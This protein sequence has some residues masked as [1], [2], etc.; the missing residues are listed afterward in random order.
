[1]ISSTS[2][3]LSPD[4]DRLWTDIMDLSAIVDSDSP[5]WTREVFSDPYKASRSWTL[6]RMRAAGL[7]AHIDGAGN[8]VGR[9][10]GTN[11]N[12]PAIITGSHTDTVHSGGRFDGVVG[13]LGAIEA[14]RILQESGTRLTSDLVVMDFL[15]EEANG[16]GVSCVGSR[17]VAGVLEA[18]HLARKDAHG[19]SMGE[20]IAGFGADPNAAVS[21]AWN[22]RNI[23]S[24]IELHVEQGPMLERS[25]SQIGVVTS[26]AGIERVMA[27]FTGR[28]DHAGTTPMDQRADALIAAAEAIL[29]VER[30]GCGAPVHGVSTTGRI[31]TGHGAFNVVPD[32]ATIW[33][34]IRSIDPSWLGGARRSIAEK[35][36]VDAA[37]RG[38][39]VAIDL[40]NDQDPV[41]AAQSMQD[42]V[43]AASDDLGYSWEAVPS[44]AG[45]DAAHMA[46]LGPMGMIFVPSQ[47]GRSHCPDEYTD[48]IQLSNGVHVL[49]NTIRRL[50]L[51]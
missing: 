27:V 40:L 34:E 41:P 6:A 17:A 32:S 18:S 21:M 3:I 47:D 29:T 9:L 45:H 28:A 4:A 11:P 31:A 20:A 49:A 24:Y 42:T 14:A 12:A 23:K 50:D 8:I 10:P 43:A 44:G 5:G 15:G 37:K 35:I 48:K 22:P 1:M 2:S 7:Q 36:A 46:H 13:V 33:A 19:V 30:V 39:D 16:F 25:G 51:A 38:V 26:I